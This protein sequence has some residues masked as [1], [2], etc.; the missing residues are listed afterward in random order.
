MATSNKPKLW[1]VDATHPEKQ[2]LSGA[3]HGDMVFSSGWGERTMCVKFVQA[4]DDKG[5]TSAEKKLIRK[6]ETGSGYCSVPVEVTRHFPDP[7]E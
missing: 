4:L 7:V 1:I 2:I 3:V 5:K 6:D